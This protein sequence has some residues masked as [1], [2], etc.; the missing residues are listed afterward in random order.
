MKLSHLKNIIKE[1]IRQLINQESLNEASRLQ[2]PDWFPP[3][4]DVPPGE[5]GD[6]PLEGQLNEAVICWA[7]VNGLFGLNFEGGD[8]CMAC[9]GCCLNCTSC[10]GVNMFDSEEDCKNAQS[11]GS[12]S[13]PGV[14][15][16]P[17]GHTMG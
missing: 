12:P 10:N 3:Q 16:A 15:R 14:P 5:H 1:Q 4:P 7:T 6:S 9:T 2:R 17:R 13:D 8:E 11:L